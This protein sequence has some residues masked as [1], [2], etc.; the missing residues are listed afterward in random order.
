MMKIGVIGFGLRAEYVV[1]NFKEFEMDVEL[2]AVCDHNIEQAK[3]R[4]IRTG[5]CIDEINFYEDINEMIQGNQLQGIIIATN[6][7]SHTDIAIQVIQYNF[8]IFL[9]KPVAITFEQAHWLQ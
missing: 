8:P 7:A 6:C 2:V 4:I 5:F 9:E 1:K 3:E